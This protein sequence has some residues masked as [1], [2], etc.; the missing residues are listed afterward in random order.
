MA[1]VYKIQ[2]VIGLTNNLSPVLAIIAKDFLKLAGVVNGIEKGILGWKGALV[3]V[4]GAFALRDVVKGF[5]AI[6]K[7][8]GDVNHQLE[9][10]KGAGFS[11]AGQQLAMKAAM[12]T[13][14][15]VLVT[16]CRRT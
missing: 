5:E 8:G 1:D 10:M 4:A 2:A 7:A 14:N 6:A 3:G 15:N 13:S 11:E 12:A 16:T 9:L